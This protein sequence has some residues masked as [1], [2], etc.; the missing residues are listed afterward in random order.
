MQNDDLYGA[1]LF[2]I[3]A[4]TVLVYLIGTFSKKSLFSPR[5]HRHYPSLF[6][7]PRPFAP[8]LRDATQQLQVVMAASFQKRRLLNL[9]E[10]RVYKI[11]EDALAT[12]G[13]GW[14]IFAQTSR[15]EANRAE[16][17]QIIWVR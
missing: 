6:E 13:R 5:R 14:R 12:V 11:I 1:A 9:S 8:D 10:Y 15:L 16:I 17:A 7:L 2:A 4:W 3:I